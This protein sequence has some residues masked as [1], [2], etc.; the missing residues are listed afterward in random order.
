MNQDL[1]EIAAF[2]RIANK[3]TYAN[4]AAAK[5]PSTRAGSQD[6]HFEKPPYIYHDTY[7]GGTKFIGAEVIYKDGKAIWG[8]NYFGRL[9]KDGWSEEV[10]DKVLRQ[11]LMQD[12]PNVIPVRGPATFALDNMTYR[13]V[14]QGKLNDFVGVEEI[15]DASG[16]AIYR[17]NVHGGLIEK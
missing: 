10:F 17:C 2:L 12:D 4:A 16:T 1:E 5:A 11:A 3:Q 6:Y 14:A 7:F 9:L 8:M 13:F 15:L